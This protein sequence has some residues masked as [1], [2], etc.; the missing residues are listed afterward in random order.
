MTTGATGSYLP[1]AHFTAE[2][3]FQISSAM[4]WYFDSKSL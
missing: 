3:F 4:D 2:S 1:V